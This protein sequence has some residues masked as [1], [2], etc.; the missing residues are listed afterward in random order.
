MQAA[1][2]AARSGDTISIADG[3]YGGQALAAGSKRLVFRAAGPGRPSFGQIVS[4]ASN[5]VV[6]GILIQDRDNRNGPC[7]D[8]DNAVLYPCGAN[9]TFENVI[10]DGLNAGDDHGIRGVGDGFTLRSSVVQNIRDQKGFESGADDMLIENNLWRRITV[11]DG[12]VH[13]ECMYVNGGDRSRV[14]GQPL[15]R[16]PDHGPLLHQLGRWRRPT[17]T[18]SSRTTS[19][20]T[21]ST[22]TAPGTRP[23]RSR[24]GAGAGNQ[25]RL[26]GWR[27]HYNTFE[28]G[29]VRGRAPRQRRQPGSATSAVS[30][31][32]ARSPTATTSARRAA[33]AATSRSAAPSTAARR[34]T[35]RPSTRRSARQ[36]PPPPRCGG[37]QP[38]RPLGLSHARRRPQAPAGRRRARRRRVR[39]LL[40]LS[41]AESGRFSATWRCLL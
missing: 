11:T 16:V 27:V 35:R 3:T 30:P 40:A 22:R 9:Q 26:D 31:A 39:A 38:G 1:Y 25:N 28:T 36:L 13:N 5:I 12:D 15:H 29:A 37:G 20:A 24:S 10:V 23:A 4:A 34:P 21:R 41:Q 7:S 2:N 14:P 6:R 19:S 17:A 32:C 8:P 33:A 18:S